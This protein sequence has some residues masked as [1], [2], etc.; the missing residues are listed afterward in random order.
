MKKYIY[1]VYIEQ[2]YN[3]YEFIFK[4]KIKF[5]D[6][7]E[8]WNTL[9]LAA[10]EKEAIDIFNDR[11][12]WEDLELSRFTK[13]KYFPNKC[14]LVENVLRVEKYN[15]SISELKEELLADEFLEYCKQELYPIEIIMKQ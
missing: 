12:E 10:D 4:N 15:C 9:I 14:F 11:Y 1:E 7:K 8:L 6:S 3:V 5:T 2:Y 13:N